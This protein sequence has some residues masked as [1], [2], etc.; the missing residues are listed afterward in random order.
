MQQKY[1][2]VFPDLCLFLNVERRK[3]GLLGNDDTVVD[4]CLLSS[5]SCVTAFA[6]KGSSKFERFNQIQCSVIQL[7]VSCNHRQPKE[8]RKLEKEREST[9]YGKKLFSAFITCRD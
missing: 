2:E 3:Q 6:K 7:C 5:T 8:K 9:V 1:F 4:V